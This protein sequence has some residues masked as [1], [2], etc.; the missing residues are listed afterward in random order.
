M[1]TS[2]LSLLVLLGALALGAAPAQDTPDPFERILNDPLGGEGL[3]DV[4]LPIRNVSGTELRQYLEAFRVVN[5]VATM[6]VDDH[7]GPDNEFRAPVPGSK[8]ITV[9]PFNAPNGTLLRFQTKFE[10]LPGDKEARLVALD[11]RPQDA[12][13]R[14]VKLKLGGVIPF[15][16][17]KLDQDG[18]LHLMAKDQ[19]GSAEIT[20]KS[21]YR[22][23]QGNLVFR[24]GGKGLLSTIVKGSAGELRIT[25]EGKL[26]RRTKGFLWLDKEFL[27]AGWK[28]VKDKGVFGKPIVLDGSLPILTRKSDVGTQPMGMDEAIRTTDLLVWLPGAGPEADT[29]EAVAEQEQLESVLD[30]IPLTDVA[31]SFDASADPKTIELANDGGTLHLTNHRL[32]FDSKGRF[33]GRTYESAPEGN[34]FEATATVTGELRGE[35]AAK[36]DGAKVRIAGTHRERIPM[37]RPEDAEVAATLEFD[38]DAA[39]SQVRSRMANGLYV[40]APK[41]GSASFKGRGELVLQPLSSAEPAKQSITIDRDQSGYRFALQGPIEVGGLDALV[42]KQGLDLP[43]SVKLLPTAPGDAVISGEGQLGTKMGFVFAKTQIQVSSSTAETLGIAAALG[44][45]ATRQTLSTRLKPGAHFELNA[46]TFAG[47]KKSA[48]DALI[49]NA[50]GTPVPPERIQLGGVNATVDVQLSGDATHT[51]VDGQGLHADLEGTSAFSSRLAARVRQG[52]R[53]GNVTEVRRLAGE[54]SVELKDGEG[55]VESGLPGGPQINARVSSGT[56]FSVS[57]G[58]MLRESPRSTVLT[59]AGYAAGQ[60]AAKLEAHLELRQGSLAYDTLAVGFAG[61]NTIDLTV[62]MG[63]KVDLDPVKPGLAG[64]I[65]MDLNLEV[66][67]SEGT[68]LSMKEGPSV[69]TIALTGDASVEITTSLQ[70]DPTNGNASLN[71]LDDVEVRISAESFDLRQLDALSSMVTQ[72]GSR[73]TITIHSADIRFLAN[74]AISIAHEGIALEIAPGTLMLGPT[75]PTRAN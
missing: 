74:G 27:G 42:A 43:S 59:T 25:P 61:K 12:Q 10:K 32:R 17:M 19:D 56:K 53:E 7:E 3:K 75:V 11:L 72:V 52:T 8:T 54:A 67:L 60:K 5:L 13:G 37:D 21:V 35:N 51:K 46:Y 26:Q 9:G 49:K 64:P 44:E 20:V 38:L 34:S 71:Q 36:L 66:A 48:I 16:R 30:Q 6:T 68:S 70:V 45:G 63:L 18:V 29:I 55:V 57:T 1:K 62:A 65:P 24:L 69:T 50:M 39:L 14:S 23:S 31:V 4:D 33:N 28:D 41:G 15:S 2:R 22:D 40:L 73:T 58:E 47:I